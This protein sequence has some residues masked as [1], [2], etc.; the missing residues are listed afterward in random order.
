MATAPFPEGL[1]SRYLSD[2]YHGMDWEGG[3]Y[4]MAVADKAV[5]R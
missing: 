1:K 4:S 2:W 3:V 5:A